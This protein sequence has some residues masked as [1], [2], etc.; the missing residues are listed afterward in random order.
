[1]NTSEGTPR[2]EPQ[3]AA[4]AYRL[5][6]DQSREAVCIVDL[7]G[8]LTSVNP[9]CERLT[10]W[11]A[12]ELVGRLVV[13]LIAPELRGQAAHQF[14]ERLRGDPSP[15]EIVLVT[16][17]GQR[18]PVLVTSTVIVDD[19][20]PVGVLGLITDLTPI[21]RALSEKAEAESSLRDAET[22]F[23]SFFASAPIGEAI[24]SPEGRFLE[25]NAALCAITGYSEPELRELTFQEITHPDDL[26]AEIHFTRKLLSGEVRTYD[27][28]KRYLHKDGRVV[29]ILLSVSLVRADSGEPEYVIKQVQDI[30]DRRD[31]KDAL[32][33]SEARLAEA[34]H[35]ARIG[36]WE[37][38]AA[39]DVLVWSAELY[40]MFEVDPRTQVTLAR[41]L[42]RIHPDDLS[43]V[44][45]AVEKAGRTGE[46]Y[47]IEHRV[48][49]T[50][51]ETRWIHGR[52]QVTLG[53]DG[54]VTMRGTAQDITE[55]KHAGEELHRL[56][57]RYRTLVEQ[58]PLGMYIRPIDMS[59]P[60]LYA[61]PQ[62]EPMIGYPA[63]HWEANAQLLSTIVHPDDRD[64]VLSDAAAIRET[65]KSY[66][67]EYRCI[68]P[69]GRIVWVQDETFRVNDED[70]VPYVMGFWLDITAQKNAEAERDRLRE[71]LHDAQKLEAIGRLAGGVAHDF[72]NMLTAIKGYSELLLSQLQP[73][74]RPY[75][76]AEQIR[77]AAEQASSLPEQLLAFARKQPLEAKVVDLND[78]V[79]SATTLLRHLVGERIQLVIIPAPHPAFAK[80]DPERIEQTLVNLA[81]NARDAMSNGG[82]LTI[83]VSTTAGTGSD[84]RSTVESEIAGS[85][86][87]I[88]VAD[89]GEGIDAETRERVFEPFFTTKP[90]GV[91]SGLG[92]ASV[93]GTVVQSGGSVQ[94]ES[95]PGQG[96]T[97][98]L[99]FPSV[100]PDAATAGSV[101][102]TRPPAALLVED[103]DLVRELVTSVLSREGFDVLEARDGVEAL[104]LIDRRNGPLDLLITDLVMPR[105]G[106]RELADRVAERLPRIKTVFIS[107]YSDEKPVT[108]EAALPGSVFVSKP[109]SPVT[110]LRAINELITV[111]V[112]TEPDARPDVGAGQVTCVIADDHPAVLDSISRYLEGTGVVVIARVSRADAAVQEIELHQPMTALVDITMEPFSG[113]E[114]ARKAAVESPETSILMYTGHHDQALLREALEAGARGFV[115]KQTPL[116][117]LLVALTTVAAGGTYV[118]ALLADALTTAAT[119]APL[120]ALTKR[121]REILTLLSGGMTN[122]KAA[123]ELGISAETIQSHVRNAMN[124]LDAD[125]RT[126]AVA[127]AIRQALIV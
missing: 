15:T 38:E 88:A 100:E 4:E 122:E 11:T 28:E 124:K 111:D 67:D 113:V 94:L 109:F 64:R 70:G 45:A 3:S 43:L 54:P 57:L 59:R 36:S 89:D 50:T 51:G 7:D 23:R 31:A 20:R 60:N 63:E 34:Q 125:T 2:P 25:V 98:R 82:T 47:E 66:R 42:D 68:T 87:V 1:M 120:V 105:M 33:R 77:R 12:T 17:D 61:S 80:V 112:S 58:L 97:V 78:L 46:S 9:A 95:E 115:L 126:Q 83:T 14:E 81:L 69:D 40:E 16:R 107:G 110:L 102:S 86:A 104:E 13:D 52:S 55:R 22:R 10:G 27:M 114:V 74:T 19:G 127:T 123:T 85:Y 44:E 30:T 79:T 71:A 37:W 93:H 96:T 41:Y 53:P 18:V 56:E 29:W 8:R 106:G 49:L 35:I 108:Q 24:V 117:E 26:E 21:R 91:G 118:D 90:Q 84:Q 6:F 116:S 76:E 72:N 65:G 92:L 99:S 121:E 32:E 101:E 119:T 5:L 75:H 103:E 62:L 39:T 48:L 73:G